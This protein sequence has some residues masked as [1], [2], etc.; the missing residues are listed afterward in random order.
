MQFATPVSRSTCTN[1][2]PPPR[3]RTFCKRGREARLDGSTRRDMARSSVVIVHPSL[4]EPELKDGQ[5]QHRDEEDPGE[6][7]RIAH[8]EE[9]ERLA[10]EVVRVE[11]RR[12]ERTTSGHHVRLGE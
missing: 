10:K 9:L 5:S 3:R 1:P 4:A 6:R 2:W 8:S 11:Q 12:I 7:A